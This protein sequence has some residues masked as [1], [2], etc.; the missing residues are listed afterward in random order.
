MR[1]A[2][3]RIV[4]VVGLTALA[5]VLF[6]CSGGVAENP[7]FSP[8]PGIAPPPEVIG[9]PNPAM[10][11]AQSTVD[12]GQ[13]QLLDISRRATQVSLD[14]SLAANAAAQST[15]VYNQKQKLDL[16]FT[17]TAV[18]L[19]IAQAQATQDALSQQIKI[20]NDATAQAQDTQG[21]ATQL[22]FLL[23]VTQT[24]GG[25]AT[26][27]SQAA[28]TA[29]AG[30]AL[31]AFPITS[32][33]LAQDRNLTE[34]AQAQM[35]LAVQATQTAQSIAALTA[36]P[37]TATPVAATKAALIMQEYNREQQSFV[38][39]VVLPLIPIVA[40]IDLVL[41]ALVVFYIG[42]PFMPGAGRLRR[43]AITVRPRSLLLSERT[44]TGPK[45]RF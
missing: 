1:R 19:A 33:A 13:S 28:Q 14:S 21:A 32:T 22:A 16:D 15:Q 34:T 6:G 38:D 39:Q 43:G 2:S 20:A 11:L 36:Y 35:I 5:W 4:L 26:L 30:A 31:T 24:A 8:T 41:F 18:S 25:Q 17:A 9:T 3:E 23:G 45:T 42:P 10:A 29:Q 37:M 12:A 40:A 27:D 7:E 44:Q